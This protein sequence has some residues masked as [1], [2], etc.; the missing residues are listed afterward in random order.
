M[1]NAAKELEETCELLSNWVSG[2]VIN[3]GEKE[4]KEEEEKKVLATM[5]DLV[6]LTLKFSNLV[7]EFQ[8]IELYLQV[9]I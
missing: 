9:V 6:F 7:C 8:L 5:Y 2:T 3:D 4:Q 1:G